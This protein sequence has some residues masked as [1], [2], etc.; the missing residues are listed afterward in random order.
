MRAMML[1][2]ATGTVFKKHKTKKKLHLRVMAGVMKNE[3][4][5][6]K[7]A[8]EYLRS[9]Y[10]AERGYFRHKVSVDEVPISVVEIWHSQLNEEKH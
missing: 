10:P 9:M 6:E 3:K 5:M 1:Y 8:K 4:V 2:I 7:L